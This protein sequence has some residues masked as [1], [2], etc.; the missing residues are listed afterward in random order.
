M[1]NLLAAVLLIVTLTGCSGLSA[2]TSLASGGGTNVA[3][4]TQ[5]GKENRQAIASF[6]TG[7]TAGRDIV[8]KEIEAGNVDNV[9]INNEDI[10]P[11]VILL[12]LLGWLAPS[13]GE[14]GRG[15]YKLLR[16][17]K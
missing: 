12:M 17:E 8:S 15:I 13:P 11:W 5:V 10:P 2:L 6:E 9:N 3:A 14:I 7:D 1:V 4:N 16:G